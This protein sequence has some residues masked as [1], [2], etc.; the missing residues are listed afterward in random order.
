ML[1]LKNDFA[2]DYSKYENVHSKLREINEERMKGRKK[3]LHHVELLSYM[4]DF[5]KDAR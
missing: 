3:V 4:L 1:N 2:V 5:T